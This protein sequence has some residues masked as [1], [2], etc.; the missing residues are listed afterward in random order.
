MR[1][2]AVI[3]VHGSPLAQLG[4]KESGGMNVYVRELSRELGRRGLLVDVFTRWNH[5]SLHQ[6]VEF[7]EG[8]RLVH[9]RA[10]GLGAIDKNQVYYHLPEFLNSLRHFQ[11]ENGLQYDLI[12]S[13]Y[14]LS[15][16]VGCLLS[17]RWRVPHAVMFHT[18]AEI[19]NRA[20][21]GE[22]ESAL[23]IETERKVLAGAD[24][25]IA[26]S[27]HEKGQMVRLYSAPAHRIEVIPCG[28]N[29]ELFRP[30]KKAAARRRL[31]LER[32]R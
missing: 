22:N 27:E 12:H 17:Q 14:W 29:L 4:D 1:R 7:G 25:V 26:A 15:G 16:W 20:R 5:P 21:V 10:G 8:A 30:T 24:R 23:R 9:L 11:Q 31:G 19:K 13:H 18:L 6:V 3:S 28:I 2:I 32:S